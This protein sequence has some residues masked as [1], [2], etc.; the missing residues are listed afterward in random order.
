M[1]TARDIMIN[2]SESSTQGRVIDV[3]MELEAPVAA[4]WRALT[5]P[6]WLTSWFPPEA[7]VMPGEG[8]SVWFSWGEGMQWETPITA[9]K[10]NAHL[11]L[12][13]MP[14]TPPEDAPAAREN[15][16][17]MPFPITV[18]YH[19]ESRSADRTVLRLV[20]AGF[21][22]G[23]AWDSQFEG[24]VRGWSTELR[25]L[26]HFL[27]NHRGEK[28][29]VAHARRQLE[30]AD[31][32]AAWNRLTGSDGLA[33]QGSIGNAKPGD[34]LDIT[35]RDG[36][37]LTGEIHVIIPPEDLC[38]TINEFNHAFLRVRIADA[39]ITVPQREANIWLSTY[40]LPPSE[41]RDIQTR[42]TRMLEDLFPAES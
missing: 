18:D 23:G 25:G 2:I 5:D 1:A 41:S 32:N 20:H 21:A 19:L 4:V 38:A 28:R 39:C 7:R 26:R 16:S 31:L 9:W 8:G 14:A 10:E 15:G 36:D 13:Y 11:Q 27:E 30:S 24:T 12:L 37:R 3:D 6:D 22:H 33:A 42:L 35:T 40:G 34:R 29:T 17:F